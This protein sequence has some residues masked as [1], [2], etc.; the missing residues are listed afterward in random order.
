[1]QREILERKNFF[2][3][4][5]GH[6]LKKIFLGKCFFLG[7]RNFFLIFGHWMTIFHFSFEKVQGVWKAHSTCPEDQFG[8]RKFD[9]KMEFSLLFWTF[10]KKHY[11]FDRRFLAGVVAIVFCVSWGTVR[12]FFVW[13]IFLSIIFGQWMEA[14]RPMFKNG[15]A[16]SKNFG[17]LTK[18]FRHPSQ[19]CILWIHLNC[20]KP[21]E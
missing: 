17:C 6:W 15:S 3:K 9:R 20:L 11:T 5:L 21:S 4:T 1:M 19:N 13:K 10:S 8:R 7:K 12:G 14:S 2:S 16:W 18:I